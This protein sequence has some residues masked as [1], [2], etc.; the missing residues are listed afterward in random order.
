MSRSL[1]L[2]GAPGS[3][4][5]VVMREV[6]DLLGLEVG[7]IESIWPHVAVTRLGDNAWQWGM[8]RDEFPGTDALSTRA[9]SCAREY[10]EQDGRLPELTLGEGAKLS[11][12]RFILTLDYLSP[13]TMIYLTAEPDDLA[14]RLASRD[15][16]EVG[17][18]PKR[19]G[20]AAPTLSYRQGAAT[21]AAN[22]FAEATALGLPTLQIDTSGRT[23][24]EVAELALG[25][26]DG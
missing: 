9:P 20:R 23:P 2:V 18:Y 15:A 7:P 25:R 10:L 3:G 11:S 1:Y 17:K 19:R 6:V 14:Q 12:L 16:G 5:S 4:K 8:V 24:R 13:V 26:F 21:R 22:R